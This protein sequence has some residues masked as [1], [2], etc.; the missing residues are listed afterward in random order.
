MKN[1]KNDKIKIMYVTFSLDHGGAEK[2]IYDLSNGLNP[3]LFKPMICSFQDGGSL[4]EDF[5][6]SGIQ[7]FNV[8]QSSGKDIT[9]PVRLYKLFKE[10]KPNIIHSH[11]GYMWLYSTIPARLTGARIVYTEH[12]VWENPTKL[13]LLG[14]K[15][16]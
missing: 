9:L 1:I 13:Y 4:R 15:I 10:Q 14:S 7:I 6:T 3:D 16:C 11:N 5:E 8:V 12:S 2:M